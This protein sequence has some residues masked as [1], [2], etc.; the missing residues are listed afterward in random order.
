MSK[1]ILIVGGGLAGTIIANGL[2][3]HIGPQ[4]RTGEVSITMLGTSDTHMYQPGLLYIPFGKIREHEL[5][6]PQRKVRDTRVVFHIDPASSID[7]D[8]KKVPGESGK[9]PESV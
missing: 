6:R 2:C 5:F 8:S 1:K 3:R 4:L 9:V 7:V